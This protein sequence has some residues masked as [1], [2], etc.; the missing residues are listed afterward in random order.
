MEEWKQPVALEGD[1]AWMQRSSQSLIMPPN[2]SSDRPTDGSV[3]AL[4]CDAATGGTHTIEV[5]LSDDGEDTSVVHG[6]LLG[7]TKW[8]VAI[9]LPARQCCLPVTASTIGRE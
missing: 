4:M 9:P 5:A 6:R 7:C 1:F 3:P 8:S 2:V